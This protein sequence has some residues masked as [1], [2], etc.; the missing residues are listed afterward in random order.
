VD[1]DHASFSRQIYLT[2]GFYDHLKDHAVPLNELAIRQLKDSA[3][4][5]DLYTWLA[6]RLPR[7]NP[8][9]PATLSWQQLANHFG[10]DGKN[11]R[12]FR[13]VIREAWEKHVSAVYPQARAEFETG[14]VKLHSSPSPVPRKTVLSVVL[15]SGPTPTTVTAPQKKIGKAAKPLAAVLDSETMTPDEGIKA[16]FFDHLRKRIGNAEMTSWFAEAHLKA[17]ATHETEADEWLLSIPGEFQAK[18]VSDHFMVAISAASHQA[19]LT[20]SP[21]VVAA[22][23]NQTATTV[24]L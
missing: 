2:E 22:K 14:L 20:E 16:R 6:Y 10:N 13:Q 19:G 3:T 18:W 17:P 11:I 4:A 9:R 7:I 1:G 15:P 12:K 5:L 21:R 24:P 8:S 23:T